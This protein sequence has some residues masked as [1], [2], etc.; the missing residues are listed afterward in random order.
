MNLER[1]HRH[2]NIVFDHYFKG[3][4]KDQAHIGTEI[5]TQTDFDDD[6]PFPSD[7]LFP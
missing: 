2:M 6:S 4:L 3:I 7:F 1:Y 5:V